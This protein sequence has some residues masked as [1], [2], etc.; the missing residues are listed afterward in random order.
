VG[1]A[2]CMGEKKSLLG[3]WWGN[4]KERDHMLDLVIWGNSVKMDAE[5]EM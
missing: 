4:L 3:F 5:V 1:H 2:E